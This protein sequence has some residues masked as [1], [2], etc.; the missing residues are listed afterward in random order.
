M[1]S[2]YYII[3]GLLVFH[4]CGFAG[5]KRALIVAISRY[6]EHSGWNPINAENDAN[7]LLNTLTKKGFNEKSI[8][9]LSDSMATKKQVV[10]AFQTLQKTAQSG[11][12]VFIH[13]STHGQQMDDDDG[14]EP[15]G[16]DEAIVCYDA[17]MFYS[18]EYKGENH[19]R[20]D[21]MDLMIL[22]IRKK[23]GETG[24]LIVSLDACHSESATR[25]YEE[26][27]VVVRGTDYV[28]SKNRG[29]ER[30]INVL[31]IPKLP[32]FQESG[33]SPITELAACE[34]N[35]QNYEYK[36]YGSLTYAICTVWDKYDSLPDCHVWLE[37]LRQKMEEIRPGQ[38][39]VL[40]TTLK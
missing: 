2:I 13:F 36:G 27:E 16:L 9:I 34:S 35:K 38:T 32:L 11:D 19:L 20:D 22:P 8:T 4:L 28:F 1:K 25:G 3:I 33:L 24:N 37:E 7:L 26:D 29:Y 6:P 14:D 39:P 21:E 30:K 5:E 15:D 40:R 18:A 10:A 17:K 31:H 12:L 23:I